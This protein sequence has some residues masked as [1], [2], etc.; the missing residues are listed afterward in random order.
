[1]PAQCGPESKIKLKVVERDKKL[2]KE[3][4]SHFRQAT[5]E[6]QRFKPLKGENADARNSVASYYFAAAEFYMVE[7]QYEEFL[8]MNFP[9]GLDFDPRNPRKAEQSKKRFLE[10]FEGKNKTATRAVKAYEKVREIKGGG[11]AWRIAGAARIGQVSQ[12]FADGLYTAEVP[13]QVRSGQFAE[14]AW[15]AYCDALTEKA[16]PLE[17][18]SVDAFKYCL[19][20]S[21]ELSWFSSWSKLCERELGQIQP[22]TYP[23]ASE[24]HV[25]AVA[26]APITDTQPLAGELK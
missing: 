9:T 15:N 6:Y 25:A 3:A 7:E 1:L 21:T 12:N 11:L 22:G 10:W 2:V 8:A 13:R 24:V 23:T 20:M 14:D 26:V 17:K 19:D 16:E 18:L 5:A 4:M